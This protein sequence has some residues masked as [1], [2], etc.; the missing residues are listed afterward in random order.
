MWEP[1]PLSRVLTGSNPG[2]VWGY[3]IL[4]GFDASFVENNY[5]FD[6]QPDLR[7]DP[8]PANKGDFMSVVMHEFG[9]GFGMTGY[10]DFSTGQIPGVDAMLFDDRSYFGG[11]G[12]PIGTDGSRNPMFFRGN[13]A[14]SLYGSD[15]HLTNKPPGNPNYAQNYFHLSSCSS[16]ADGLG[17]TLMNGGV[18]PNGTRMEITPFDAAVFADL[19]YPLVTPSG[20][21]NVNHVIDS[22]DYVVW[23]KSLGQTGVGLKADGNL[24]NQIDANDFAFW[25]TRFGQAAGSG[26]SLESPGS[27]MVPEPSVGPLIVVLFSLIGLGRF[28]RQFL[29]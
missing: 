19:G 29:G 5:W 18:L 1:G 22:A 20:D 26:S 2:L 11:N 10:R 3:D 25:R 9:H 17:S 7:S 15:L 27:A 4:L 24:N 13:Y 6:P 28:P 8:V 23:R 16:P 21:Y 12:N 14:A